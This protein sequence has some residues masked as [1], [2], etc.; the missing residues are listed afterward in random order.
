M[1]EGCQFNSGDD[2]SLGARRP[3]LNTSYNNEEFSEDDQ[4]PDL[5]PSDALNADSL[6]EHDLEDEGPYSELRARK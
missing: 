6:S 3:Q 5:E 2:T 4:S 1:P